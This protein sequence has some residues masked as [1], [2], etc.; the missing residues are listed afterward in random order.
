MAD[1]RK[2]LRPATSETARERGKKGG[3][4][5][6]IARRR[7]ANLKKTMQLLLTS[8][9]SVTIDGED[10]TYEEALCLAM[11]NEALGNGRNNVAAFNAIRQ[12]MTSE[13]DA[14][15][16]KARIQKL[17]AETAE[18][19]RRA[20]AEE[21]EAEARVVIVDDVPYEAVKEAQENAGTDQAD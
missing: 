11:V 5:S 4:A 2:N 21:E 19:E 16:R 18:I 12:V 8:K 10:V 17:K 15:E 20:Q 1:G 9:G 6:G 13:E 14:A 7:K 3:I